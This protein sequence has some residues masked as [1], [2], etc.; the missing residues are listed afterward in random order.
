MTDS[1]YSRAAGNPGGAFGDPDEIVAHP[2]LSS[3]QKRQLLRRWRER[4]GEPAGPATS[5]LERIG[6]ALEFL[7]TETGA[8][9]QTHEQVLHGPG[10]APEASGRE[11]ES[12]A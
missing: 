1:E 7:D 5:M 3:E 9:P 2:G 4:L 11:R 12:N 6:R 8:Q 10:M